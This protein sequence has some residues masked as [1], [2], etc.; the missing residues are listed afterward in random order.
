MADLTSK[1]VAVAPEVVLEDGAPK[2][3]SSAGWCVLDRLW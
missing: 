3:K 1:D 2:K